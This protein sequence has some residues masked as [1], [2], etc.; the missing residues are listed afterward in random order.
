MYRNKKVSLILP[1]RN[2]GNH[3]KEVVKRVPDFVD[4]II[5]VSNKSSDNTMQV[6]AGLK[7]VK[8]VEDNRT[9]NGIGYGFAHMTGIANATGDIIAAADGDGTYP[10]ESLDK[11]INR[12]LSKKLDFISC[13]RYPLQKGT[14][15]PFKL[16]L[17]VW[18]LNTEVRLL[19]GIKIN[20]ILSG[21]WVFD[22]KVKDSL[23]LTMGEWNLSPQ[24]KLNAATSP[25][26]RFSEYSIAQH[27]RMGKSHQRHFQTGFAHL[28]WIFKNRFADEMESVADLTASLSEAEATSEI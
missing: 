7:K 3:L 14:K 24:I 17:G 1:C 28:K 11:V 20:D 10:I 27:Q 21:M 5:V 23:N 12:L 13:N 18:T 8:A 16:R 15:I 22:G 2:E 25:N 6:A 4:E 9:I 19:Y 26:I